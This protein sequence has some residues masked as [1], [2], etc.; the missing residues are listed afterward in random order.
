MVGGVRGTVG[1]SQRNSGIRRKSDMLNK[2]HGTDGKSI[3][4]Y[5]SLRAH[6]VQRC[7]VQPV[8]IAPPLYTGCIGPLSFNI[9]LW[10]HSAHFC[11]S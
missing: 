11:G 8:V 10:G 5:I 4:H 2:G 1:T 7:V 9:P 6:S 3:L